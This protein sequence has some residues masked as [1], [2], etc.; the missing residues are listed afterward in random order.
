MF[1]Y[2]TALIRHTIEQIKIS[3]FKIIVATQLLYI[4]YL[5]YALIVD[6]GIFISN[7]ILLVVSCSYLAFF[8]YDSLKKQTKPVP[9][10]IKH[11][12]I[13]IKRIILLS[14]KLYTLIAMLIIFVTGKNAN[15]LAPIV[16]ILSAIS[17]VIQMVLDIITIVI[18][19]R[20]D[21][22]KE[23]FENDIRE[24]KQPFTET[25]NFLKKL[26]G[27]GP[28]STEP[29]QNIDFLKQLVAADKEH[30]D[31]LKRLRKQKSLLEEETAIASELDEEE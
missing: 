10:R 20:I 3:I 9:K 15:P 14:V 18:N 22:F 19:K 16:I 1:D 12:R 26:L 28:K 30:R 29:T 6:S 5:I 13:L 23:A 2:T 11:I 4:G 25:S 17:F 8:I 7:V 31:A 27:K 24:I 21:L